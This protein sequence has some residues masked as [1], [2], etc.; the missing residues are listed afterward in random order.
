MTTDT[1]N[2]RRL[3]E[4]ATPGPWFVAERVTR[5][6]LSIVEDGRVHGMFPVTAE[7][8]E[9]AYIAAANPVAILA[10]LDRLRA[11]EAR[12]VRLREALKGAVE[13]L[14]RTGCGM[15]SEYNAMKR[16]EAA[17]AAEDLTP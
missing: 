2:L 8:H 10:L 15:P 9:A 5:S 14:R 1:D 6:G 4:A 16:G 12:K 11:A 3:A 7:R 17:L 13:A